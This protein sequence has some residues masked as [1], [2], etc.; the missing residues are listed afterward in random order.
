[1]KKKILIVEDEF[2]I[3]QDMSE[4]LEEIGYTVIGIESKAEDVFQAIE[5]SQPDFVILDINLNE[6]LDGVQIGSVI[7][8]KYNLPF[9][10]LTAFTDTK[11]LERVKMTEP[12]GY[13]VKP[14]NEKDLEITLELAIHKHQLSKHKTETKAPSS[15]S[16]NEP[17][18]IKVNQQLVKFEVDDIAWIEAY[19]NYCF[20]HTGTEKHLVSFTLKNLEEKITAKNL[21]RIHRS[22]MVNINRIEAIHHNLLY[23][24]GKEIPIGKSYKEALMMQ[25]KVL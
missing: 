10:Y 14:F 15:T 8:N 5:T 4:F 1:M 6:E 16:E 18:F 9:I 23:I 19:D 11:T 3:A 12:Y 2:F 20:L 21:F 17:F 13:L 7:Q 24:G 22:Y 25:L